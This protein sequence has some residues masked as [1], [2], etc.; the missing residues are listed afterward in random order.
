MRVFVEIVMVEVNRYK[1]YTNAD[2]GNAME[3]KNNN[4][5]IVNSPQRT[6]EA[7]RC[8]AL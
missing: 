3:S 7:C 6:S 8:L 1:R 5:R 4:V 2:T